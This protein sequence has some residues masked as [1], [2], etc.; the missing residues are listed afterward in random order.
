MRILAQLKKLLIAVALILC[1]HNI[2]AADLK[3]IRVIDP[4]LLK[5]EKSAKELKYSIQVTQENGAAD[6]YFLTPAAKKIIID[7][8]EAKWKIKSSQ[9]R[10][11]IGLKP[12][13]R[14]YFQNLKK[15]TARL[16]IEL[17]YSCYFNHSISDEPLETGGRRISCQN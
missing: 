16:I 12:V 11:G 15:R 13:R 14:L 7:F 8:P 5:F 6:K 10:K 9:L 4:N 2:N 1:S 3:E 17:Y